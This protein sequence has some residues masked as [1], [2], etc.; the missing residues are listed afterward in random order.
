MLGG[1]SV[2]ADGV[3]AAGTGLFASLAFIAGLAFLLEVGVVLWTAKDAPK[4]AQMTA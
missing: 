2:K 1:I 4:G 3:F